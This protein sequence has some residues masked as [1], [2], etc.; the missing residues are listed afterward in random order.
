MRSGGLFD[1]LDGA[2][3]AQLDP[4]ARFPVVLFANGRRKLVV[5]V[6]FEKEVRVPTPT[7][8]LRVAAPRCGGD[9]PSSAQQIRAAALLVARLTV[10]HPGCD[11]A[12]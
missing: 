4:A 3:A 1:E 5:P 6:E 7:P 11:G 9:A 10:F 8:P 2:V 12:L